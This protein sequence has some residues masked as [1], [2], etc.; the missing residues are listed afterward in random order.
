MATVSESSEEAE[1]NCDDGLECDESDCDAEE[2]DDD[3]VCVEFLE[4]KRMGKLSVIPPRKRCWSLLVY[5]S[6]VKIVV[7]KATPAVPFSTWKA[8][9]RNYWI[10]AT[11]RDPSSKYPASSGDIL[12]ER[13]ETTGG[14]RLTRAL[15]TIDTS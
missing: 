14:G 15:E 8:R 2:D 3:C 7:A 10:D 13:L 4:R 12:T 11:I 9:G 5:L 1:S 6:A